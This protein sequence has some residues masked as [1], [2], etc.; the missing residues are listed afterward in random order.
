MNDTKKRE[1]LLF[2]Q[3]TPIGSMLVK[4]Y[5]DPERWRVIIFNGV[6]NP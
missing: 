5:E 6:Y 4:T 3:Q 2:N 1:L